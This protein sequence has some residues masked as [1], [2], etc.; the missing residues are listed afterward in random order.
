M[1]TILGSIFAILVVVG[2]FIFGFF[3]LVAAVVLGILGWIAFSLRRWWLRRNGAES[4]G[5]TVQTGAEQAN[6]TSEI[7][8]AEYTVISR[9]RE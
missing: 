6:R 5:E 8:E 2:M 4:A 1:G 3:V 7:I 9:R